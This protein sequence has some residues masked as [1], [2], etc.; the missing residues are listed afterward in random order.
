MAIVVVDP[1]HG[2]SAAVG[3]SSPNNATG[4]AGT[5]EKTLT[6][7]IGRRLAVHL[8]AAGHTAVLTRD[9]DVNL[10]LT[11]RAEIARAR[12]AALFLSIHLNGDANPAIQGSET[13]FAQ[14]AQRGQRRLRGCHT[15]AAGRGQRPAQSRRQEQGTRR[16]QFRAPLA[17]HGVLPGRGQLPDRS[18]RGGAAGSRRL[19]GRDR[20]GTGAGRWPTR[21]RSACAPC[22]R[23]RR[24][25][26]PSPHAGAPWK[27]SPKASPTKTSGS[28]ARTPRCLA[29]P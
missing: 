4:P 3:G 21:W 22:P 10:G 18:A 11:A 15:A 12:Q 23:S 1:G 9:A 24:R 16:S 29:S 20:Q 19:P 28:P 27:P 7:Q 5:L 8:S 26:S 14:H 6:L 17:R 13:W 2:G 25:T